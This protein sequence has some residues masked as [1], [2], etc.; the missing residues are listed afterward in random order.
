[1]KPI[2]STDV[3]LM[4]HITTV[5]ALALGTVLDVFPQTLSCCIG[6]F[7]R[8]GQARKNVPVVAESRT[9]CHSL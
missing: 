4:T 6:K 3:G 2:C 1:M 9:R 5:E 8:V 7:L